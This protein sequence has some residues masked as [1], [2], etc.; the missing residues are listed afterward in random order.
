MGWLILIVVIL[1]LPVVVLGINILAG[2]PVVVSV[3]EN[4]GM[5]VYML[6]N[7]VMVLLRVG[8]R[9]YVV[10]DKE[11]RQVNSWL[12]RSTGLVV[13]GFSPFLRLRSL[14]I[15]RNQVSY[16]ENREAKSL[17]AVWSAKPGAPPVYEFQLEFPFE[18]KY[19]WLEC[20]KEN[21]KF[22]VNLNLQCRFEV[23]DLY[24]AAISLDG[25]IF[26]Q[27]YA[28]LGTALA[29][30]VTGYEKYDDLVAIDRTDKK[31]GIFYA[32]KFSTGGDGSTVDA[33]VQLNL[34]EKT[35][36]R[37][38]SVVAPDLSL[39]DPT[40]QNAIAGQAVASANA[41]TL[42]I[43]AEAKK[44]ADETIA[45]G[46]AA[47]T[48]EQL[49]AMETSEATGLEKALTVALGIWGKKGGRP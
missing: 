45:K 42:Q 27:L 29:A 22:W 38:I 28:E 31:N 13:I 26:E 39:S 48:A 43:N 17:V 46:E 21:E 2:N 8:K 49:N 4:R 7:V 23:V 41:K 12:S 16:T 5:F 37:L 25:K 44:K 11:A 14:P 19:G 32:W 47:Y 10:R 15:L 9:T 18:F 40:L 3:T 20:G 24:K 1:G 35:G 6:R 34:I 30:L 33:L 36:V